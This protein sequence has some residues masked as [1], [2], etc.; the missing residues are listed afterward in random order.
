MIRNAYFAG[1]ESW[2]ENLNTSVRS[3]LALQ[4]V[5]VAWSQHYAK[6]WVADLPSG[7]GSWARSTAWVQSRHEAWLWSKNL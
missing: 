2:G 3:S 6:S 5:A 1:S 4:D 7:P